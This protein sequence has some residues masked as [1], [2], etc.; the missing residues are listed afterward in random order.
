M[1]EPI[2]TSAGSLSITL[3][4]GVTMVRPGENPDAII[5]RADHAMYRAKQTGRN[6]VVPFSEQTDS[7]DGRSGTWQ[8]AL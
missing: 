7:A 5:T 3:S 8:P 6:Q 2:L 1:A 4:I